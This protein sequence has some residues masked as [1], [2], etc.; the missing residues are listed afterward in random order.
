VRAKFVNEKFT[1]ESDPIKD[2]GIGA[3]NKPINFETENKCVLWIIEHLHLILKTKKIPINIIYDR[4]NMI[5]QPYLDIVDEYVK[6][7]LCINDKKESL[8]SLNNDIIEK[9]YFKLRKM[10]FKEPLGS[11]YE[12]LAGLSKKELKK[13]MMESTKNINEKFTEESDPIKD[14]NIGYGKKALTNAFKILQFI[15][16][17]KEEGASFTEIQHFIWVDLQGYDEKEFW[18]KEYV[19]GYN[20]KT[21]QTYQSSLRKTRGHWNTAL[22]GGSQFIGLLHQYCKK[23]EKR[24]WVLIKWPKPGENIFYK[25]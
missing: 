8:K 5:R 23:N 1:E 24:K 13:Y 22:Y 19:Q 16:S 11:E 21:N 15:A 6:K 7:Y 3:M 10:G 14:M 12:T 17:K 18:E 20:Y 25:I 9:M 2:M 4:S